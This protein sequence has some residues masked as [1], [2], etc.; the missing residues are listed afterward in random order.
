MRKGY[1]SLF[2]LLFCIGTI[3]LQAQGRQNGKSRRFKEEVSPDEAWR[4]IRDKFGLPEKGDYFFTE[5]STTTTK[6]RAPLTYKK[7][8]QKRRN[9]RSYQGIEVKWGVVTLVLK[10]GKV[11]AFHGALYPLE[12]VE[13]L[14]LSPS[15]SLESAFYRSLQ[16]LGIE[17]SRVKMAPGQKVPQG[18]LVIVPGFKNDN[19]TFNPSLAWEFD[20]SASDPFIGV[21]VFADAHS[22]KVLKSYSKAPDSHGLDHN[23]TVEHTKTEDFTSRTMPPHVTGNAQTM[24]YGQRDI[25]TEHVAGNTY[26]LKGTVHGV[27]FR[28]RNAGGLPAGNTNNVSEIINTGTIWDSGDHPAGALDAQFGVEETVKYFYSLGW[29]GMDGNGSQI[30]AIVGYTGNNAY[31]F[32][33]VVN[34]GNGD[35]AL[36]NPITSMDVVGHEITHGVVAHT[37]GLVYAG[38][39]GALNEAFAD[40]FGSVVE[41]Y[42]LNGSQSPNSNV[43]LIGEKIKKDGTAIR[44]MANPK[45]YGHPDTY[46]GA[47]WKDAN[48][49]PTIFNDYGGVHTNSGVLNR[50]FNILVEGAGGTNDN[51]DHYDVAG[52]GIDAAAQVA[53]GALNLLHPNAD[54]REMGEAAITAA[55]VQFG[56]GSD[57]EIAVHNSLYAVGVGD[58]KWTCGPFDPVSM[59]TALPANNAVGVVTTPLSWPDNEDIMKYRVQISTDSNFSNIV[60]D[61][62]VATSEVGLEN[63]ESYTTYH[64]RVQ[65]YNACNTSDYTPVFS[66]IT[67]DLSYPSFTDPNLGLAL[68]K[69]PDVDRN[70]NG[71]V[72]YAEALL[73]DSLNLDYMGISSINGLEN[74]PNLKYLSLDGNELAGTVDLT[75]FENLKTLIIPNN[76]ITSIRLS[77]K[78]PL[79]EIDLHHNRIDNEMVLSSYNLKKLDISFNRLTTVDLRNNGNLEVL[80]AKN[81]RIS[82]MD[83]PQQDLQKL[84]SIDVS[85]NQLTA[86]DLTQSKKLV[87]FNAYF[88]KITDFGW[89]ASSHC[90]YANIA[91]NYLTGDVNLANLPNLEYVNLGVNDLR[92][93]VLSG[94]PK[95]Q[96]VELRNNELE[97]VDISNGNNP[98]I[99]YFNAENNPVQICIKIDPGFTPSGWT[100]PAGVD[101]N[102]QG[103]NFN[104]PLPDNIAVALISRGVSGIRREN[105]EYFIKENDAK[106]VRQLSLADGGISGNVGDVFGKFPNL[107][108][109]NLRDNGITSIDL[110]KNEHLTELNAND[111]NLSSITLPTGLK[112]LELSANQLSVLNLRKLPWLEE[113]DVTDNGLTYFNIQNGNN[114]YIRRFQAQGNDLS[115]IEVDDPGYSERY[116]KRDVDPGVRFSRNCGEDELKVQVYP[117]LYTSGAVWIKPSKNIQELRITDH[118]NRK[119]NVRGTRTF[120]KD[121]WGW[122]DF[123]ILRKKGLYFIK[124]ISGSETVTKKIIVK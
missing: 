101:Y 43:W 88:N 10:R 7:Y 109:L 113:V 4:A 66:F 80:N 104:I 20:V 11:V 68:I 107:E 90:T 2:I 24:Y 87:Y 119:V 93:V 56:A 82:R 45:Q 21:K 89:P 19:G 120:F 44:S 39:S 111:N 5:I 47:N 114:A 117:T 77:P 53:F 72:E 42:A 36:Y 98:G 81:N 84:D 8:Q 12:N 61:V 69:H 52:I 58:K 23:V 94:N 71:R 49:Q 54:Y 48:V 102:T 97:N 110:S 92:Q 37:A 3:S 9:N 75:N 67:G 55:Q 46:K 116:W 123:S 51:G 6:G 22:G 78:A 26:K 95:L 13:S 18:K 25:G 121:R 33:G 30:E 60:T 115:C 86:L 65:A 41:H 79:E 74:F 64:W 35:G 14:S 85:S 122:M 124:V 118:N 32:N 96:F 103:C 99:V 15:V 27:N 73:V 31:Y 17:R 57:V 105:G 112:I 63:L 83:F 28:T 70:K 29:N 91:G 108:E 59:A 38:E 1:Q 40:I 76:G 62:E 16:A 100:A 106:R 50:L 34:F